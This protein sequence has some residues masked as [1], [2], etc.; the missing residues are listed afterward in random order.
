MRQ[1]NDILKRIMEEGVDREGRNGT[2]RALFAIQM[3]FN[4]KDSFPAVTT[5]KLAFK[6]VKSEL[7]WFIEGSGDD[8]RLKELN[9]SERTIWTD[10]AEA[11]Y[12]TPKAKFPGDLGRVYGVQWRHWKRPDGTETDQLAAVIEKIKT[13]PTDR[14]LVVTAWN[15]GELEQMALPPC[16]MIFQFFP[17]TKDKTLSLH[18]MQ[19]SCDMFL[20]VPFNIASYSLLLAMVAQCT[21]YTPG[22][23]VLTLNDAHI[24]HE[25]FDAVA[26]QLSREPMKAPALWLNPDITD[27]E[28]FTMDDIKLENYE[29]HPAIKAK[30]LV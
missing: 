28:K 26:E 14:R 11:D 17:N 5:K 27:I 23:C 20:G 22:E 19:R 3:R 1:Y 2:T 16:H 6:A 21:G 13:N 25:H 10:N 29:S 18:M 7:L 15:P 12:W 8:N 4:L 30:M 9:G 24:Y